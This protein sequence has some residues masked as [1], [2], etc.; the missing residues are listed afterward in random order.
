MPFGFGKPREVYKLTDIIKN[1]ATKFANGY[2]PVMTDTGD[3]H[4][5]ITSVSTAREGLESF[6]VKFLMFT[7]NGVIYPSYDNDYLEI[8]QGDYLMRVVI[9]KPYAMGMCTVDYVVNTDSVEIDLPEEPISRFGEPV[10]TPANKGPKTFISLG[11][12]P[13]PELSREVD[14]DP[15]IFF[16]KY[17]HI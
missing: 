4:F 1:Q 14:S 12:A 5:F 3:G 6:Y 9:K 15:N 17:V 11:M 8:H 10:A 13:L 2:L 7:R 16:T